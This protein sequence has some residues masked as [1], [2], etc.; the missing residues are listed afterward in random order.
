M[1]IT[2]IIRMAQNNIC[3]KNNFTH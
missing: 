1:K 3:N 2:T